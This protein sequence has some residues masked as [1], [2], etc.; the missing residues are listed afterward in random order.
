MEMDRVIINDYES[1]M[2]T[3]YLQPHEMI[4]L[5]SCAVTESIAAFVGVVF[6]M[7]RI[8]VDSDPD[9]LE[10]IRDILDELLIVPDAGRNQQWYN[11]FKPSGGWQ[12]G[13]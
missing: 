4:R 13:F 11:A 10:R 9:Y 7:E 3:L 6:L 8:L 12:N 5:Y 1:R 2:V